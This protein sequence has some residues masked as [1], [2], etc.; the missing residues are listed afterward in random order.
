MFSAVGR[1][2]IILFCS[3]T[4]LKNGQDLGGILTGHYWMH[5]PRAQLNIAQGNPPLKSARRKTDWHV[6]H[7]AILCG[8]LSNGTPEWI[9]GKH[10]HWLWTCYP[11]IY[12]FCG[13]LRLNLDSWLSNYEWRNCHRWGLKRS[14]C[15]NILSLWGV[16][17]MCT[18]KQVSQ[19]G[20][21]ALQFALICMHW[22][23]E[24]F[25]NK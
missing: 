24:T 2:E 21:F 3:G 4:W 25:A 15:K 5:M 14:T 11:A 16:W 12:T 9:L 6:S 17:D 10:F 13:L 8:T 1:S 20:Q 22:W 18:N 19:R 23:M 7:D